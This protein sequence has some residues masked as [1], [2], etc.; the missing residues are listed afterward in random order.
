MVALSKLLLVLTSL[1]CPEWCIL[2]KVYKYQAWMLNLS[3]RFLMLENVGVFEAGNMFWSMCPLTAVS[4]LVLV[5]SSPYFN[6]WRILWYWCNW[7]AW[8]LDHRFR[9][10]GEVKFFVGSHMVMYYIVELNQNFTV[11]LTN[12]KASFRYGD[13]PWLSRC[14]GRFLILEQLKLC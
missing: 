6:R 4:M 5:L 7:Q 12:P 8:I 2:R 1:N 13:R 9:M 10:L 3:H 14:F 11:D